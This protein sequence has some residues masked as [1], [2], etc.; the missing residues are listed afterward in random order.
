[1]SGRPS[2]RDGARAL[3]LGGRKVLAAEF[4]HVSPGDAAAAEM[5]ML[6]PATG[7]LNASRTLAL[8]GRKLEEEEHAHALECRLAA[9]RGCCRA[10]TRRRR[11]APRR[12]RRE[13][14][15]ASAPEQRQ[16]AEAA[17]TAI[18]HY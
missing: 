18:V 9:V 2:R 8:S 3:A 14:A 11:A 12:R 17:G 1:M 10:R 15:T 16:E 6:E 13:G 5:Q 7:Q 4:A